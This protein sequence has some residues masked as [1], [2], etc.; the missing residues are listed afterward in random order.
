M[1]QWPHGDNNNR[2]HKENNESCNNCWH[3]SQCATKDKEK[4]QVRWQKLSQ[5]KSWGPIAMN[6]K[7][8]PNVGHILHCSPHTHT[9]TIKTYTLAARGKEWGRNERWKPFLW[10]SFWRPFVSI[11]CSLGFRRASLVI[12][13]RNCNCNWLRRTHMHAD[14]SLC[15]S[16][17]V[18]VLGVL[19]KQ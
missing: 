15:A 13:N 1:W 17:C 11:V 4:G 12:G 10:A 16:V 19:C 7:K 5:D 14:T 6:G 9:R 8:T 18:C 3:I 2:N